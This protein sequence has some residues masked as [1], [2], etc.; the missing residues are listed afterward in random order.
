MVDLHIADLG[1]FKLLDAVGTCDATG[2]RVALAVVNRDRDREH[3][4]MIQFVGGSARAGVDA[5]EVNGAGPGAMNS[6]EHPEAV[7]VR[8]KRMNLGGSTFEHVS[9][10][11]SVTLLRLALA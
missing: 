10:A 11:H 5:A 6:F 4:V 1:P 7:G 2:R 3:R 9:P 8:E